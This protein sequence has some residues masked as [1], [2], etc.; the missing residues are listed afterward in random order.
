MVSLPGGPGA[1]SGQCQ[2]EGLADGGAA[3]HAGHQRG[4]S[5]GAAAAVPGARAGVGEHGAAGQQPVQEEP[6]VP[7]GLR[8]PALPA[9]PTPVRADHPGAAAADPG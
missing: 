6:A 3:A 5:G 2:E 8:D 9:A 7:E 4:P 1:A